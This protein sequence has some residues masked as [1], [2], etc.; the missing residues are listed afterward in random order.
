MKKEFLLFA[1]NITSLLQIACSHEVEKKFTKDDLTLVEWI[2]PNMELIFISNQNDT[3]SFKT[4]KPIDEYLK[5]G[6]PTSCSSDTFRRE[7]Y[8]RKVT[9]DTAYN[10][11]LASVSKKKQSTTTTIE[12]EGTFNYLYNNEIPLSEYMFDGTVLNDVLIEEVVYHN[13]NMDEPNSP[14]KIW[15]SKKMGLL[16]YETRNGKIWNRIINEK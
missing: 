1:L 12:F 13:A 11:L 15:W 3:V 5:C 8:Y 7:F 4:L 10:Y 9:K 16:K 2:N 14:K 6:G